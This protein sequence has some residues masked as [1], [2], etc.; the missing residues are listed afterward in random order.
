MRGISFQLANA[1]D[2]LYVVFLFFFQT[3]WMVNFLVREQI[4]AVKLVW[5]KCVKTGFFK[6]KNNYFDLISKCEWTPVLLKLRLRSQ[7]NLENSLFETAKLNRKFID[8]FV[9]NAK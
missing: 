3:W 8:V 4:V 9:S 7:R 1:D 6:F 2:T 5:I